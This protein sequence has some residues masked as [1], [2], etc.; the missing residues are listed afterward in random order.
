[1]KDNPV[2][3][4]KYSMAELETELFYIQKRLETETRPYTREKLYKRM[5]R[6]KTEIQ[7]RPGKLLR[8]LKKEL[9]N[10]GPFKCPVCGEVLMDEEKYHVHFERCREKMKRRK[11]MKENPSRMKFIDIISKGPFGDKG[12]I[13][14]IYRLKRGHPF[15][16]YKEVVTLLEDKYPDFRFRE[17]YGSRGEYV[18]ILSPRIMKS[19]PAPKLAEPLTVDVWEERDRL[20]IVV[21]DAKGRDVAEWWDDDA[22]QMFEDGFFNRRD[23]EGSVIR[24]VKEMG[25][26]PRRKDVGITKPKRPKGLKRDETIRGLIWAGAHVHSDRKWYYHGLKDGNEF[27]TDFGG[28]HWDRDSLIELGLSRVK[29]HGMER[30]GDSPMYKPIQNPDPGQSGGVH[31]DIGSHNPCKRKNPMQ[32]NP[33]LSKKELYSFAASLGLH[34]ASYSPGDGVTRHRVFTEPKDYFSGDGIFTALGLR[35]LEVFLRGYDR[36]RTQGVRKTIGRLS[37]NPPEE[38]TEIYRNIIEIRAEK[39]DGRKY[40]HPFGRGSSIYGLSDGSI[41]VRNRKGKRLWKNFK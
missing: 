19:N 8:A 35:E 3:Y 21:T 34:V 39:K 24:Y 22:R 9:E 30:L 7:L 4:S 31:I 38:L 27:W 6:I 32:E 5:N 23:L 20:S 12:L 10:P 36:C 11:A 29:V 1:M 28:T 18:L 16:N 15:S 26:R 33:G 37:K 13:K 2:P 17:H 14:I 40:R 25:L 41:L